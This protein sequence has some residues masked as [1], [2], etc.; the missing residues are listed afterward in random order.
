LS[1]RAED[2]AKW[3]KT[4]QKRHEMRNMLSTRNIMHKNKMQRASM[5]QSQQLKKHVTGL[6]NVG[7]Y[8]QHNQLSS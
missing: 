7:H 8:L 5:T 1:V 3:N 6:V 2:E 4:E